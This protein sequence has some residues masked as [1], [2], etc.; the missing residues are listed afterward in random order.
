MSDHVKLAAKEVRDAKDE[1]Q[2]AEQD[3]ARVELEAF[4][5]NRRY[6]LAQLRVQE[7][8]RV[9]LEMASQ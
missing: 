2:A 5:A 9:L 4:E 6:E 8:E 7:A 3:I 1:L